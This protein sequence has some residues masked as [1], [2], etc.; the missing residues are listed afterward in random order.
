MEIQRLKYFVALVRERNFARAAA[1]MHVTQPTLS[2][3]IALLERELGV[4]LV[5]RLRSGALPTEAGRDFLKRA[6]SILAELDYAAQEAAAHAGRL[7][8]TLRLGAIPTVAP[9]VL[10]DLIASFAAAHPGVTV[11]AREAVTERLEQLL[12]SG[13]IDGAL[14]ALPIRTEQ[15]K[16]VVLRDEPL[17]V[18]VPAGHAAS[19]GEMSWKD[20]GEESWLMLEESHCLAVQTRELCVGK[21]LAPKVALRGSQIATLL[22]MVARGLGVAVVPGMVADDLPAG[23]KLIPFAGRSPKRTIALVMRRDSFDASPALK[24]FAGFVKSYA[25]EQ[26][27]IGAKNRRSGS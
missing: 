20:I 18:A 25:S 11:E 16:R 14:V 8:G 9:F 2:Q 24:A 12:Q 21:G 17:W 6:N 19:E 1:S 4:T 26:S 5:R 10:P 15:L 13:E 7:R 23:V 3:Q 22:A 27:G